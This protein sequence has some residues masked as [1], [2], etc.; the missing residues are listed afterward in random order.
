MRKIQIGNWEKH[1]SEFSCFSD[2]ASG[3]KKKI[4]G[5]T[6]FKPHKN[7]NQNFGSKHFERKKRKLFWQSNV[8]FLC[9]HHQQ[10]KSH[11]KAT[12]KIYSAMASKNVTN[13]FSV[14][15]E[16]SITKSD[17]IFF[18]VLIF[19]IASTFHRTKLVGGWFYSTF[20]FYCVSAFQIDKHKFKV[21]QCDMNC[22]RL[23]KC[24]IDVQL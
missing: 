19:Y 23:F 3:K 24:W 6:L 7:S 22:H 11:E 9:F 1:K 14:L 16:N 12:I 18:F 17:K 4:T 2:N 20:Q 13:I 15:L 8:L 21:A 10:K 5:S